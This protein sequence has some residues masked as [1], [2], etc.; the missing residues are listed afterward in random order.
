MFSSLTIDQIIIWMFNSKTS[1]HTSYI[2]LEIPWEPFSL[3]MVSL[4]LANGSYHW[5]VIKWSLPCLT[6]RH[7]LAWLDSYYRSRDGD[8]GPGS[9]FIHPSYMELLNILYCKHRSIG[10]C[11]HTMSFVDTD[12][13]MY[14]CTGSLRHLCSE[15]GNSYLN[16]DYILHCNIREIVSGLWLQ[17]A[18]TLVTRNLL[19]H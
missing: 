1:I 17:S 19:W 2:V 16:D 3:L 11:I 9:S 5:L 13:H 12:L 18:R 14:L 4:M 15:D 7:S 6:M 8:Q 10:G